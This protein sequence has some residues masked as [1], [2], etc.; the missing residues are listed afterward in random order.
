[1]RKR[2]D[3]SEVEENVEHEEEE[4][5]VNLVEQLGETLSDLALA[6]TNCPQDMRTLIPQAG[7]K[8]KKAEGELESIASLLG[9][10]DLQVTDVRG[11]V[12]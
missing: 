5:D 2:K 12:F 4:D 7:I 8:W 3:D 10:Q 9:T 6:H 1:M 11:D